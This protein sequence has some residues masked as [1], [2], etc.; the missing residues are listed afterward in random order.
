MRS[1]WINYKLLIF[2]SLKSQKKSHTHMALLAIVGIGFAAVSAAPLV[3]SDLQS[4]SLQSNLLHSNLVAL[5]VSNKAK[6]TPSPAAKKV[7]QPVQNQQNAQVFD[8]YKWANPSPPPQAQAKKEMP[9]LPEA[10]NTDLPDMI[11]RDLLQLFPNITKKA[12]DGSTLERRGFDVQYYNKNIGNQPTGDFDMDVVLTCTNGKGTKDITF[13]RRIKSI[14][15]KEQS[16]N[17]F[18]I[19]EQWCPFETLQKVIVIDDP[20]NKIEELDE[21]N[22]SWTYNVQRDMS[23]RPSQQIGWV[24]PNNDPKGEY[25]FEVYMYPQQ[26][27][28]SNEPLEGLTDV[29]LT[30]TINN[31]GK[32]MDYEFYTRPN[33]FFHQGVS[34]GYSVKVPNTIA[35]YDRLMK[36]TITVDPFNKIPETDE[37]NNVFSYNVDHDWTIKQGSIQVTDGRGQEHSMTVWYDRDRLINDPVLNNDV[38]VEVTLTFKNGIKTFDKIY[39]DEGT[40]GVL[41]IRREWGAKADLVAVKVV[42]DPDNLDPETNENNNEQLL[43]L[44]PKLYHPNGGEDQVMQVQQ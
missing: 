16:S 40:I 26:T 2:M 38:N 29:K 36:V 22:N 32:P 9:N 23:V 21:K 15:P 1:F 20:H 14:N 28:T 42:I 6:A 8:Q 4:D 25:A 17:F 24:S 35:T 30:L 5:G 3:Q 44:Q 33:Y 12:N 10:P 19:D 31:N 41:D 37:T 13:T 7:A 18:R 34:Y 39:R 43:I 11:P 27:K